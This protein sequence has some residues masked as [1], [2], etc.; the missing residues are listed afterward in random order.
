MNDENPGLGVVHFLL[1][2]DEALPGDI[3][4]GEDFLLSFVFQ[5][6]DCRQDGPQFLIGLIDLGL[7]D[8]CR[9]HRLDDVFRHGISTG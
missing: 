1:D 9:I 6:V 2:L 5:T 3:S 4:P 7:E 8:R